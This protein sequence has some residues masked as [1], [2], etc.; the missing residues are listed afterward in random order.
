MKAFLCLLPVCLFAQAG[1]ERPR[2]G[3]ML[4]RERVLRPVWGISG[5]FLVDD[6]PSAKD[7]LAV[8]C[9]RAACV[10]KTQSSVWADGAQI[11]APPGA[12]E[13]AMETGGAVLHFGS[14]G[15]FA[16]LE[17]GTLT[18][19]DVAV[20]GEVLS[21]RSTPAGIELAVRREDGIWIVSARDGSILDALPAETEAVLLAHGAVV[22]STAKEVVLRRADGSETRFGA[23]GVREL[24]M[25]G[26]G[27]VEARARDSIFALRIDAGREQMF[28]LP[29]PRV[30]PGGRPRVGSGGRQ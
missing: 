19:L 14:T 2:L 5:S 1:L 30:A 28:Q 24:F 4:D 21:L 16:R 3:Q 11:P 13:I 15:G 6:A 9:S 23:A 26:E 22:F 27:W 29:Q 18:P 17:N 12:A 10:A 25:M 20:S 7:V 8:A